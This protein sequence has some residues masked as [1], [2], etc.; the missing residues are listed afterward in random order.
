MTAAPDRRTTILVIVMREICLRVKPEREGLDLENVCAEPGGRLAETPRGLSKRPDGPPGHRRGA[1]G[2]LLASHFPNQPDAVPPRGE[3]MVGRYLRERT[4]TRTFHQKITSYYTKNY[5]HTVAYQR[6]SRK[7]AGTREK[8]YF[9]EQMISG[10]SACSS[11]GQ[12]F[13]CL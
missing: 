4:P 12:C 9:R 13:T 3:G 10:R 1:I 5:K 8:V 2:Y 6:F 11:L 7:R